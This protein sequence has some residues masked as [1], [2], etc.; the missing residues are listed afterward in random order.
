MAGII[1]GEGTIVISKHKKGNKIKYEAWIGVTNL[2]KR[3]LDWLKNNFGGRIGKQYYG[4]QYSQW[5][6]HCGKAADVLRNIYPFLVIK[7]EQ[8][9]IFFKFRETIGYSKTNRIPKDILCLREKYHQELKILHI[10]KG[11]YNAY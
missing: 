1:D 8:A 11:G 4:K 7:Q 10:A 6:L 9:D 2:D 3:L 5:I